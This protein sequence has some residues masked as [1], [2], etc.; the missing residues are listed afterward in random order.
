MLGEE[1]MSTSSDWSAFVQSQINAL[2]AAFNAN[3]NAL[4][5]ALNKN[6]RFVNNLRRL[7]SAQKRQIITALINQYNV[8]VASLRAQLNENIAKW[9]QTPMPV[10]AL[11]PTNKRALLIGINYVGTVNELSGCINDV[12]CVKERLIQNGF[13]N[14]NIQI[15][16]DNTAVK[17]TKENIV[18]QLCELL[19]SGESG[20]LLFLMYSGHGSYTIDRNGDESSGYDQLIVPLDLNMI[21]DDELKSLIQN[22][23]KSGVTLFGMFDSCFSGSVLDLRYQYMDSLNYDQFTENEK[24][25]ETQGDVLMISGCTDYQTSADAYINQQANGAMTWSLLEALK[26]NPS[27]CTWRELVQCMRDL[28]KASQFDQIPQF[29]SGRLENIDTPIFI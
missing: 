8:K 15:L 29:S 20:D 9:Q 26:T 16:T 14:E 22:N 6:I 17:P 4:N 2:I 25:L 1:Y 21:V 5:N 13:A 19:S 11:S 12:E 10:S 23:L 28:L 7:S 18:N 27:S 3:V 24:E